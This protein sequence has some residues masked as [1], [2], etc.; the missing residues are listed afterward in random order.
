MGMSPSSPRQKL[1]FIHRND[2]GHLMVP[3]QRAN[4][5]ALQRRERID[6]GD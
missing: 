1:D 2:L 6:Y 5:D 3:T 4:Y